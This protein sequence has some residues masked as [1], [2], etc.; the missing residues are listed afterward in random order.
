MNRVDL[1][2]KYKS[3]YTVAEQSEMG[4]ISEASYV[5]ILGEENPGAQTFCEKEGITAFCKRTGKSSMKTHIRLSAVTSYNLLLF[6][7][8]DPAT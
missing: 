3:Y 4:E 8:G 6:D 1:Q 7:Y 5:A 2:G